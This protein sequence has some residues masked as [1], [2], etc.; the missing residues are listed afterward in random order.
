MEGWIVDFNEAENGVIIWIRLDNGLLKQVFFKFS[1]SLYLS[2]NTNIRKALSM[3]AG[4]D[5]VLDAEIVKRRLSV[6]DKARYFIKISSTSRKEL[7]QVYEDTRRILNS[8]KYFNLHIPTVSQFLYSTGLFPTAYIKITLSNDYLVNSYRILDSKDDV[9]YKLPPL[10]TITLKTGD[11]DMRRIYRHNTPIKR[12]VIE[13]P[14]GELTHLE[15]QEHTI[16]SDL[17]TYLYLYDPD[18]IMTVG[19]DDVLFPY[20]SCRASVNE[21]PLYMSRTKKPLNLLRTS[22]NY[23]QSYFSYGRVY[24][25]PS[26]EYSLEGRIHLDLRN[27]FLLS[28]CGLPGL[29]EA[30]RTCAVPLQVC[31]RMTIGQ[32]MSSAQYCEAYRRGILV[33]YKSENSEGFKSALNL[34]HEDKGGFIFQP[35]IGLFDNVYECDF[36]SMYPN[37]MVSRNVSPETLLQHP[38][39]G[40]IQV[41][42]THYY[43]TPHPLG[44][45]PQSIR[46]I[47]IKRRKYKKERDRYPV[48]ELR[49]KA[50]KWLLVTSFGFLGFHNAKFGSVEAH[51]AVTAYAREIMLNCAEMALRRGWELLHGIVDCI[52]FRSDAADDGVVKEYCSEVGEKT[53][54]P[55]N[56]EGV[57]HWLVFLPAKKDPRIGA[58][59][60]Y[61]GLKRSGELKVRGVEL[62]RSDTPQ[63]VKQAQKKI[64]QALSGAKTRNEFLEAASK[65]YRIVEEY[66][67]K[68]SRGDV[69]LENL[70]ISIRVSKA[71]SQYKASTA[72]VIALKQFRLL[73]ADLHPGQDVSF[74]YC[75]T[76]AKNPMRRIRVYVPACRDWKIHYDA[77]K[78]IELVKRAYLNLFDGINLNTSN[79]TLLDFLK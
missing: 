5:K 24:H 62:R 68:I 35:K 66:S 55:L 16:L 76:K 75:N 70:K 39:P 2:V 29:I 8:A 63:I 13:T 32:V 15:G 14:S 46:K 61:Y 28:H 21:I 58:L 65:A 43:I 42:G 59:T 77:A 45:V 64:L 53:H 48:Y 23:Y 17:N 11:T 56:L 3:V 34:L 47:L 1:P 40:Y 41:P 38:K 18:I 51:M 57:Y 27:S 69:D 71:A 6:V 67:D 33:P 9:D 73:G 79:S 31:S 54:I 52:W 36:E 78:Y 7:L 44:I 74:I 72:S 37:I 22:S 60:R 25:K 19:G 26:E 4:H 49:Q 20:L 12:L 10:K 30:A 50:L